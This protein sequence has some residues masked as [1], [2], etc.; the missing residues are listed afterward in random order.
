M[1]GKCNSCKSPKVPCKPGKPQ[2]SASVL[3]RKTRMSAASGASVFLR[4]LVLYLCT[5]KTLCIH[6]AA[7]SS[8]RNPA[9]IRQQSYTSFSLS[10][11]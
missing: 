10:A 6:T 8:V 7:I 5:V 2:F 11:G 3:S 4:I 9:F 1:Y